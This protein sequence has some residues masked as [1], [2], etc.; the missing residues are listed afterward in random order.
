MG[1]FPT[2]LSGRR[3]PRQGTTP[4]AAA[5]LVLWVGW[6]GLPA[7]GWGCQGARAAGVL[8]VAAGAVAEW[9]GCG[10][11][12]LGVGFG[13]IGTSLHRVERRTMNIKHAANL[14]SMKACS[15]LAI[16][17]HATKLANNTQRHV[18]ELVWSLRPP[19]PEQGRVR[20]PEGI[21]ASN[22]RVSGPRP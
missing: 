17:L 3:T 9:R 21:K 18:A 20:H 4:M 12:S 1:C 5:S 13:S 19:F 2:R 10:R 14:E 11:G 6:A 22:R 8:G 7:G 15:S 16:L